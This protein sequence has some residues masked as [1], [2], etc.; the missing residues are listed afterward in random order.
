M[1]YFIKNRDVSLLIASAY[2][3]QYFTDSIRG[4]V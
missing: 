4:I 3:K 2:N 1:D